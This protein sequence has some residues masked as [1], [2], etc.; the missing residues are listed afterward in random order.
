MDISAAFL[1]PIRDYILPYFWD[2]VFKPI[3]A[4][5]FKMTYSQKKSA[6][7]NSNLL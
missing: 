7:C 1:F 5:S 6:N 4:A 2:A 3:T